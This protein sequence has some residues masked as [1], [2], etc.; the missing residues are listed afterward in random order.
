M[1]NGSHKEDTA[2]ITRNEI[3]AAERWLQIGFRLY[4]RTFKS[5]DTKT[6]SFV[7]GKIREAVVISKHP[8]FVR[9]RLANGSE[10]SVLWSDVVRMMRE[11]EGK[12]DA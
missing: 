2:G 3:K 12:Q 11:R 5:G 10:D 9:V 6:K 8:N 7:Y 4:I 1:N